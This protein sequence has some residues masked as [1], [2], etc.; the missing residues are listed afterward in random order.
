MHDRTI[1]VRLG[2]SLLR[3]LDN[4][5]EEQEKERPGVRVTRSEAI[6]MLILEA[7]RARGLAVFGS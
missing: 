3:S 4:F 6:R 1:A 7:L 2:G 5:A